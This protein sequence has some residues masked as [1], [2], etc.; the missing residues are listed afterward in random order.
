MSAIDT[1]NVPQPALLEALAGVRR[2]AKTLSVLFGV[3]VVV[4]STV[5]AM[6]LLVFMD[7]LFNLRV[8]PR[9]AFLFIALLGIG[10]ALWKWVARPIM[11]RLTIGDVAGHVE[12]VF[13]QFEDRI[14][15]TVD[16]VKSDSP[17]SDV[18]K[19]RVVNEADRAAAAVDLNQALVFKPVG[20]SLAAG[21][22]ALLLAGILAFFFSDL[23]GIATQRFTGADVKYPRTQKIA[24]VNA[25]PAK[26]A[27]GQRFDL[28]MK[29]EKG[30]K[31]NLKAT[32]FIKYDNGAVEKQL[33]TRGTDGTYQASLDARGSGMSVWVAAGD[34]Q[35]EAK[36]IAVV[37]RLA[38]SRVEAMVTP[39]SYAKLEGMTVNLSEAPAAVVHGSTVQLKVTFN[40][41]LM[42]GQPVELE[43]VKPDAKLPEIKWENS[44]EAVAVGTMVAGESMRF[45][46]H[47][48]DVDNFQNPALEEYDIVVRPDQNPTVIIETP[49]RNE[50]RTANAVVPL[51]ALAED[52]FD[53]STMTLVVERV[54]DKK[55][56]EIALEGWQ[57]VD[58][59]GD[60][61]RFRIKHQWELSELKDAN[62]APFDL[63]PGDVLEYYVRVT[64]NYDY[65]G[66]KHAPVN[67]GKLKIHVISQEQLN[68]LI[69]D[70]LRAVAEKVRT[71]HNAQKRTQTETTN[72][73]KDSEE[74]PQMDAGDRTAL[75][76][77]GEQQ[78]TIAQQTKQMA[79]TVADIEKRL[80]E[81]R[82][83]SQELKDITR[84]VK[85]TLNDAAENAMSEA[86]RKLNEASDKADPKASLGRDGKPDAKK[87]EQ[88]Q[89]SRND[90]MN[91]AEQKQQEA[92]DQLAKAMDKMSNLGTFES[93]IQK[94]RDALANQQALSKQTQETGKQTIGKKPEDLTAEQKKKL[95]DI[96]KAQ[97]EQAKNTEKIAEQLNKASTQTQKSDPA[98]SQA[99]KQAAQQAQQQQVSQSQS[100]AAQQ[101]Q[102]NQ[103]AQAQAKQKQAELGLQIM[104]DTLRE[105]ERRKLEQLAKE[106]TKLQD[107]IATLIRR[108]AG[109]NIDNLRIQDKEP[110]LKLITEELLKKAE[111]VADKQPAKPDAPGL[112]NSQI[113]TERN[114]RDVSKSAE[115]VQKSGAEIAA[116]LT[117][118][119]GL[120]ERAVVT[121]KEVR[122]PEAFDPSQVRALATLEDAKTLTDKALQEVQDQ[123]EEANKETVRAAYEKIKAEQ[124]V[125]NTKTTDIDGKKKPDGTLGAIESK[126]SVQLS[127]TQG[128]LSDR[129]K[130]LEKALQDLGGVV[131]VWANKDIVGSMNDVKDDLVKPET[132]AATQA[133]ELRIVEQLD[134]MI[135][136]LA[137]KKKEKEFHQQ[138]GGGG[139]GGACKPGLPS[140]AELRL[141]KELQI[142]INKA[143]KT[144]GG[145]PKPDQAKLV[146]L[147]NRQGELRNLLDTMMQ[148]ASQGEVKLEPEP[149]PKD[150][151]P[152]E[153]NAGDIENQE[154]DDFLKNGKSSD[155]QLADDVKL[156]GQRMA[157]S[158]QRL[159]LDNDPGKTTQAIQERIL[160]NLDHLIKLAQQ[161]EAQARRQPG[162]RQGQ[163]QQ[164]QR[165]QQGQDLGLQK[166]GQQGKQSQPNKSNNG[167]TTEQGGGTQD[168]TASGQDIRGK[169]SE[170]GSLTPRIRDAVIEGSNDKTIEKY[171]KFT[172]D[173]YESMS[174][175]GSEER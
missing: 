69:T 153:A 102:Q 57:K 38:I 19:R 77:I 175:K 53:I 64:D 89:Q 105:A 92:A 104:L 59:S 84:E 45:R 35:T 46:I 95:D 168:N 140:E 12:T 9:M 145:Q 119:A 115:E 8:V 134:A 47:A 138:A 106:L 85:T 164:A 41:A 147:G 143:T 96:A 17:G 94:V 110:A 112:T 44:S 154:L 32:V 117:K 90:A 93:L 144:I 169:A 157:R 150:R 91:Q 73:K 56:A 24:M 23:L 101:A 30:D 60:R 114:A 137:I 122:L 161:Q 39:P 166:T 27:A 42:P 74:K 130:A 133:E 127:G 18:M 151:L 131:Y 6:V 7:W 25:L 13:P 174:K 129:T 124:V 170:W 108:Q 83:Q 51:E 135:R 81:N 40:K 3:G 111:R 141:L 109:H 36:S 62:G 167:A 118:A 75:N 87:S 54:A 142:A 165:P 49:R 149:D 14:R 148:K 22:G 80:D 65:N 50:E 146:A 160:K 79:G 52:D 152:E 107:L 116:L 37:Q 2:K 15:S 156:V 71:T 136:N 128:A 162:N 103:Q 139:G 99:M 78:G 70:A 34:D 121:L 72:L 113:T 55:H 43:S 158:R 173:Y 120:M 1:S 29:L 31:P 48:T 76:R 155:D 159:A 68:V 125:I 10:Y 4:A 88:N 86:T 63:K 97:Q 98:A 11:A 132:G 33:M 58:S 21:V 100:Q 163:G 5:L 82:A 67:S 61:R 171:E 126:L 28:K 26:V 16:F 66:Q 172:R 123:Q 20:Y